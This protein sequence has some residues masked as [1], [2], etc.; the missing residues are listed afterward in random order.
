MSKRLK[1]LS[2]DFVKWFNQY[3]L[4][5]SNYYKGNRI[6]QNNNIPPAPMLPR[7]EAPP[8]KRNIPPAPQLKRQEIKK[9]IDEEFEE[10]KMPKKNKSNN[11]FQDMTNDNNPFKNAKLKQT[12]T[13]VNEKMTN[14]NNPFKNAKL[15][16]SK[17]NERPVIFN[18]EEP[19]L[20]RDLQNA[21]NKR[22][23]VIK[24][25]IINE[26][27]NNEDWGTGKKRKYKRR[28]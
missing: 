26:D 22:R 6:Q 20:M 23:D 5:L 13:N 14:E 8:L 21:M 12:K 2:N 15:N 1:K 24:T 27:N 18:N 9:P 3:I 28:R 19:N 7:Q 16:K 25:E 17:P 4:E 10:I 11:L